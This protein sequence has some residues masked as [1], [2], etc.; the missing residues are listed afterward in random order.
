[1]P[2]SAVRRL[3]TLLVLACCLAAPGTASAGFTIQDIYAVTNGA[4]PDLARFSN[5][6][7]AAITTIGPV[8]GLQNMEQIWGIDFEPTSG[9]LYALGSTSRLYTINTQTGAA[10]AVSGGP[11][12]TLVAPTT[13][14]RVGVDIDPITR[15]MR[16]VTDSDQN[17]RVNLLS[18]DVVGIDNN[19]ARA[20][21]DLGAADPT[22]PGIA[23]TNN[24]PGASERT[25]FGYEYSADDVVRIGDVDGTPFAPASG[26]VSKLPTEPGIVVDGS[27][28]DRLDLDASPYGEI[29]LL[30]IDAGVSSLYF[31]DVVNNP[32]QVFLIGATPVA[33]LRDLAV[34]PVRN[35][36]T[37]EQ[38]SYTVNENAGTVSLDVLR[39]TGI[40]L[41][42]VGVETHTGGATSP[43]DF[44]SHAGYEEFGLGEVSRT[45]FIPIVDDAVDEPDETF[46]VVIGDPIGGNA[47]VGSPATATVTIVDDDA[48]PAGPPPPPPPPPPPAPPAPPDTTAPTVRI[49][50]VP[51]STTF[52]KF[53][54]GVKVT[55]APGEPASIDA[56]LEATA[57][58]VTI[59]KAFNLTL[60]SR[61]FSRSGSRR[62]ITLKPDRKLIGR[63]ARKMKAR[64][65]V[66]LTDGAGNRTTRN[67]TIAVKAR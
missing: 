16:V 40:G 8:T 1:M 30:A 3:L 64:V 29:Y 46:E 10:T 38:A 55:V 13:P 33:T 35:T 52:A 42:S 53:A 59:A 47:T 44:S 62:T 45:V 17:L 11:F 31:I 25:L 21:G 56:F 63:R 20:P 57:R 9:V 12:S 39:S 41:A 50:G 19:L 61:S 48:A 27:S 26:R 60:A 36:F 6:N 51:K 67:L 66:V 2:G 24:Y 7:P 58:R 54:K 37:L 43:N 15:Q 5:S 65:R 32:G 34:E 22:I 49:T 4:P 14:G 23:F 18:G 28:G